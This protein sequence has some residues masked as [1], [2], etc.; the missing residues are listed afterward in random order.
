MVSGWEDSLAC[1]GAQNVRVWEHVTNDILVDIKFVYT[2]ADAIAF[3]PTGGEVAYASGHNV[4]LHDIG[5]NVTRCELPGHTADVRDIAWNSDG[6]R[7]ATASAD[8]TIRIW[9]AGTGQQLLTL[10]GDES[11][12]ESVAWSP[13]GWSIASTGASGT[14]QIWDAS[15]GYHLVHDPTFLTGQTIRQFRKQPN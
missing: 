4:L 1:V 11:G 9:D 12:T 2:V 13:D 15:K 5:K 3:S 7:L 10:M 14:I 8:G 6:H